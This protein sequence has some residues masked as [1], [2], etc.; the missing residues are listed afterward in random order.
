MMMFT[1]LDLMRVVEQVYTRWLSWYD[2]RSMKAPVFSWRSCMALALCKQS[3]ALCSCSTEKRSPSLGSFSR[4]S[5]YAL[6][7]PSLGRSDKYLP[8]LK[9]R[10]CTRSVLKR[11]EPPLAMALLSIIQTASESS[12]SSSMGFSTTSPKSDTNSSTDDTLTLSASL[13]CTESSSA[14]PDTMWSLS[15]DHGDSK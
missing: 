11:T 5:R 13:S 6:S 12:V 1:P 14:P 4:V 10:R 15:E 7:S 8:V 9:W 2:P 3:D